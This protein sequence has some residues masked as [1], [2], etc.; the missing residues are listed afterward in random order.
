LTREILE[1]K[2]LSNKLA[3]H[4]LI[5]IISIYVGVKMFGFIGIISGPIYSIIA[6]DM[7]YG[8]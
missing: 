4:P 6:K 8:S 2:F 1:A 7:I 3:I 5:V